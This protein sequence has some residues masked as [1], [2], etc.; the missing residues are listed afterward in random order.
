MARNGHRMV[1]DADAHVL[2]TERTWDYLEGSDKKF[3][4]ALFGSPDMDMQ[5]W[6][7]DGKI[8]GA[9]F[10]TLSEQQ[11]DALS[12]KK[13]RQLTTPQASREVDDVDLRL[14]H[15]DELGVDVQ[16]MHNTMWI[17]R[18]TDRADAETALCLAWNRWMA[19]VWKAGE[20]RL[21]W[22]CVIPA[23]TLDEAVQQMRFAR[24]HGAVAV[25]M[26]P[27]EGDRHMVDPYF[28]PVF[29]EASALDLAIGVHIANAST[30]LMA[31]FRPR[32]DKTGGFAPFRIP[33]VMTCLS[34]I[35]SEVPR[36]FPKLRWGFIETS[37]QWIPWIVNEAR[38][39]S[40][41]ADYPDNPLKEYNVYVTAQ[42][43]DDFPYVLKYAG[44]DN[45]VIG[46]DYGHT[47]TSSEVDA[48]TRF[49]AEPTV[50]DAARW[51]ILSDNPRE[52]YGIE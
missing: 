47:D 9:R 16:V 11:L 10:A 22:S 21:R 28:Y 46:T 3:R 30:G 1:V 48:I 24:E 8:R 35:M 38:R 34:L 49:K 50:D 5:Y 45:I 7:M 31:Q 14:A 26:R 51:K 43:D 2:E 39:R 52:L 19:D 25:C 12:E 4:P 27:F 37:A 20:G 15:L 13:G 42:C 40:G 6:V 23:M 36:V 32:Y 17:E 29:E 33:T 44:E 18:V 41:T